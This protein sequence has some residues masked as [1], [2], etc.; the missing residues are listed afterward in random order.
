V[1]IPEGLSE[2]DVLAAIESV[3]RVLAPQFT[4]G[5]F[6]KDDIGQEIR[7]MCLDALPRYK[8]EVGPLQNFLFSHSKLRCINFKRDH[9]RRAD[10]PCR[11]CHNGQPCG[12]DGEVCKKYATWRDIQD[13]KAAIRNPTGFDDTA[14]EAEWHA[15]DKSDVEGDVQTRELL[16]LIDARLPIDLRADYLRLRAGKAIGKAKKQ[17]VEAAVREILGE[18]AED[19]AA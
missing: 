16:R 12:P 2:S 4:F 6:D 1:H 9:H 8:P 10:A 15:R 11:S 3:V 13:R 19:L 5:P 17:A 7:V 18:A 14:G